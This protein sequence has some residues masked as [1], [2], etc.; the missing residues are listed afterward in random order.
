MS[1]LNLQTLQ[2]LATDRGTRGSSCSSSQN[3]CCWWQQ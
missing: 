3:Q 1:V 2:P